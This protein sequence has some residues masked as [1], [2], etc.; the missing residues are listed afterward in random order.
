MDHP[1][2]PHSAS[3]RQVWHKVVSC[4]QSPKPEYSYNAEDSASHCVMPAQAGAQHWDHECVA[5]IWTPRTGVKT[6]VD[7][8]ENVDLRI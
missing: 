7:Q 5:R 4:Q 1:I 2:P 6:V 8:Q 3:L